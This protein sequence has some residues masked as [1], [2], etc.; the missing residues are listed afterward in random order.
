MT[1][2]ILTGPDPEA[3]CLCSDLS[4]AIS[5]SANNKKIANQAGS[6]LADKTA[7]RCGGSAGL[8]AS[9]AETNSPDFP[10]NPFGDNRTG[11]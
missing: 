2:L 9:F 7:Y 8:V 4:P 1:E 6:G 5:P 10:F 3:H 11:T